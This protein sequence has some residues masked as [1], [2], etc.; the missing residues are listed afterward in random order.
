MKFN[1][2]SN[3]LPLP[4]RDYCLLK[5]CGIYNLAAMQ[6][7]LENMINGITFKLASYRDLGSIDINNNIKGVIVRNV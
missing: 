6:K 5:T 3:I 1:L 7:K 2:V 4:P